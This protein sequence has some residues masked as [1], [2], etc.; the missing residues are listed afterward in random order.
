MF[1]LDVASVLQPNNVNQEFAVCQVLLQM[2]E[3]SEALKRKMSFPCQAQAHE[4]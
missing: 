4:Q 3:E 2:R 1:D